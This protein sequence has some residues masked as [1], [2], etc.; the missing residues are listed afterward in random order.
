[1]AVVL[2]LAT[3]LFINYVDRGALPTA[4]HLIQDELKLNEGQ[5]GLLFSAFFWTYT[6]TQ[7]PV[8]WLAERV[9]AQRVL[10]AGLAIWAVATVS[11]GVV[12]SFPLLLGLRML[13]GVGESVGFPCVNKLLAAVVP[14]KRLGTANGV[15]ACGY[16][17]G[18]AVGTVAGGVIMSHY[19]WRSAFLVF[20]SLSLLWLLPWSRVTLPARAVR[21]SVGERPTF[22]E[23]LRCPA[24][25]GTALG[26]FSANYVFYF[27]L[28]WLPFYLVRERGFSTEEMASI[29]GA[30]YVINALSALGVG[31]VSDRLIAAGRSPNA[32]YK[33]IMA[34]AHLGFAG[35]MLAMAWGEKPLALGAM[36]CFQFLCGGQSPGVYAI[37]QILGGGAGHRALGGHPEFGGSARRHRGAGGHG[38]HHRRHASFHGGVLARRRDEFPR[39]HRLVVDAAH[40][41]GARLDRRRRAGRPGPPTSWGWVARRIPPGA[42]SPSGCGSS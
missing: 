5:L 41:Q 27:M 13:L 18:P 24:L 6:L 30:A 28:T 39:P 36:F 7:I 20:G 31:Y 3:A 16:L 21:A 15:V 2:L 23:L 40:A 29:A 34:L 26:L 4:A 33:T 19:G 17:F 37:P 11:I 9:G 1:V 42:R 38:L 25:W 14:V 12:S 22:G 35:C 32:V 8:G 10:A